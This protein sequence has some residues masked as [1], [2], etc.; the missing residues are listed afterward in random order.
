MNKRF[1][2]WWIVFATFL[3]F[4]VAVGV[5]YYNN[6]FFYDYFAKTPALG[7]F[8]WTKQQITLG[9][10]L[11]VLATLWIGPILVP[12]FSPRKL[13]MVGTGLTFLTYIGW[14]QMSGSLWVYYGLWM[15]YTAGYYLSGPVVHQVIVSQWFRKKRGLAMGVVYVGVGIFGIIASYLI[16]PIA[17]SDPTQGFRYALLAMGLF[18]L[19]AWP[20][21]MWVLKDRPSEVGQ[22]PDGL[23]VAPSDSKMQPVPMSTLWRSQPFWLLMLGSFCSIG[24][25]GAIN[26]HL[27]FVFQDQ[28][29]VDQAA[30]N[31]AWQTANILILASS[32]LGRVFVGWAA[33]RLQKKFVMVGTYVL[34]AATIPVLLLVSPQEPHYLYIFATLFGFGMGAD[35]MLIPLM[36]AEQFGVN[37]LARA[38]S[39]ILPMDTIGQTWFPAGVSWLREQSGSYQTTLLVV[40]ALAFT[41]AVA[42]ALL[43]SHEKDNDEALPV[44]E[45]AGVGAG[46]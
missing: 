36:A 30:R 46:R 28:G 12:R 41:G 14:S 33:D 10:P 42:I 31:D 18:P 43:P 16:K 25:I 29:F 26:Q 45:P 20:I 44:Q 40:F 37:S 11:A 23:S 21:A 19:L 6:P 22:F 38:M 13:I 27:K 35:Y 7:G 1:Y 39:I 8:G 4:G 34:V 9:F 5:P 15:L 3:T 24:S 32:I 17:Q 2:G